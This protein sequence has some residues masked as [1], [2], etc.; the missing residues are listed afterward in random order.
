MLYD[1]D[2]DLCE[3]YFKNILLRCYKQKYIASRRFKHKPP[4]P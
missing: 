3:N 4:L 1:G 2:I